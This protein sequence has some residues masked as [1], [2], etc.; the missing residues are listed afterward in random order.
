MADPAIKEDR[1]YTYRD[2]RTWPEEER[3]ELIDG[4]AYNMSPAPRRFHQ[5]I[6]TN[7]T[8]KIGNYLKGHPCEVYV[9]PFDVLLPAFGETEQDDITTVVQPDISVICDKAKL[10][11][12]GCTGAP[13]LVVEILS[14]WTA[15]KD[16][17][18][19]LHLYERHGVREYWIIDPGNRFVHVYLLGEDGTYPTVPKIYEQEDVLE[20][21]VLSGFALNCGELFNFS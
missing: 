20:S 14:H 16:F 17:N 11:G 12:Q 13:D 5:W 2:Y 4:A 7:L 18:E 9:S 1:I 19:K 6:V 21:E 3:W 8:V 10:T 15:K